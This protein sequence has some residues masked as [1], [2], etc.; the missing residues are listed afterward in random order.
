MVMG[1]MEY[2]NSPTNETHLIYFLFCLW[3]NSP[4]QGGHGTGMLN[5]DLQFLH[6]GVIGCVYSKLKAS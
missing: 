3:Q 2:W 4:K 1:Y 6:I 5:K